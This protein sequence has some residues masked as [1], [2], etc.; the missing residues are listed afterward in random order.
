MA[1]A[2]L[3]SATAATVGPAVAQAPSAQPVVLGQCSEQAAQVNGPDTTDVNAQAGNGR[4]TVGLDGAGN[5]TVFKYPNPSYY[6]QVKYF[7][8]GPD[9]S[10]GKPGGELP[11]EGSFAGLLFTEVSGGTPET[12]MQWLKQPDLGQGGWSVSQG[13]ASDQSPIVVTTFQNL[14]LGLTVTDTDLANAGPLSDPRSPAAFVRTIEVQLANGSPV[15]PGTVQLVYYEHFDALGTRMRYFPVEDSCFQ[16]FDDAQTGAYVGP[17]NGAGDAIV[18]A[19]QGVDQANG[20]PSSVAFAFGFDRA[21]NEHQVGEDGHDPLAPPLS[22]ADPSLADGYDEMSGASHQ[23]SGSGAAVGQVTGTLVSA[24]LQLTDGGQDTVRVVIGAG[25]DPIQAL[26]ALQDE[27]AASAAQELAQVNAFWQDWLS[28]A[29]LPQVPA[30]SPEANQAARI[31]TVAER[32]LISMKL[33]VDPDS[34][35]IVAS[36][37]TQGPYGEDWVRDGSFIDAALDEAGYHAMVTSHE[38]FEAAAQNSPTNLDPTAPPGNW[39]MNVYGDGLPGGPIPYEIDETGFGAWTLYQHSAYLNGAAATQYLEEVF[40]AIAR[41]ADWLTTCKDPNDGLQCYA[42]EDDNLTP[43]QTLHGAGPDLLGLRSAVAAAQSLLAA[44]PASPSALLWA[45]EE[46]TWQARANELETAIDKLYGADG[47][48]DDLF[49]EASPS[50]AALTGQS[51]VPSAYQVFTDGGW[52]LWPVVLHPASDARMQS[53]A[54]AVLSGAMASLEDTTP[55][56]TGS[57]EAKGLLGVCQSLPELPSTIAGSDLGTIQQA[58]GTLSAGSAPGVRGF[59]TTTT[60]LFAEAWENYSI[61]GTV[62]AIPLNDEPHVWEGA[63]Y[64]MTAMC[65]FPPAP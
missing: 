12:V 64:Y 40:P 26:A 17:A 57:Y 27:R 4:I 62:Q 16:Q 14:N 50:E 2:A 13:Y 46:S 7:T 56:Y 3:L 21:S 63:L 41:A 37:D 5:I 34:G 65:A 42:N 19:W 18:Q 44:E 30:T 45:Q 9:P 10:T 60:G 29:P 33:A 31:D 55:G 25:A 6:N 53:E 51:A 1:S 22:A 24:P 35:A 54:S 58:V 8:T 32:A 48:G 39:P 15:V 11:N 61:D 43:T 23:L 20:Q 38:L 52:L 59:T 36:A 28:T 49:A 47:T